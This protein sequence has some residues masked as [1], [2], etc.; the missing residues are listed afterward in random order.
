MP[1]FSSEGFGLELSGVPKKTLGV[2]AI[3]VAAAAGLGLGFLHGGGES[4]GTKAV[5][6]VQAPTLYQTVASSTTSSSSE[7]EPNIVLPSGAIASCTDFSVI[8][9]Q[10]NLPESPLSINNYV[11]GDR[12]ARPPSGATAEKQQ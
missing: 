6:V 7:T 10:T 2:I 8:E 3:V 1:R 9:L 4:L 12:N 5:V 11:Y